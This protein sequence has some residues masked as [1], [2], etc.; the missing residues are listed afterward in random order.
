[1]T[2]VTS[3]KKK[4]TLNFETNDENEKLSKF[5]ALQCNKLTKLSQLE[6]QMTNM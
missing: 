2:R 4:K 5:I 6:K 3:Y 1:M